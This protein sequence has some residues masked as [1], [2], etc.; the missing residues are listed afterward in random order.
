MSLDEWEKVGTKEVR[1]DCLSGLESMMV[2]TD[3]VG[4]QASN[5]VRNVNEKELICPGCLSDPV[6]RFGLDR[7]DVLGLSKEGSGMALSFR[8]QVK[9]SRKTRS[10]EVKHR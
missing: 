2:E 8:R 4:R 1:W 7:F 5:H 3:E 6:T 10:S 9:R